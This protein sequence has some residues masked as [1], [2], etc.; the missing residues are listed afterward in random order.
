MKALKDR[1]AHLANPLPAQF[2]PS[3][4]TQNTMNFF[5]QGK[6]KPGES[7][8]FAPLSNKFESS[9]A[10]ELLH[11]AM[12]FNESLAMAEQPWLGQSKVITQLPAGDGVVSKIDV[13]RNNG[14]HLE[15]AHTAGFTT[16]Y[17]HVISF[18]I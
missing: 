2:A 18:S 6:I 15:I 14:Q 1:F 17:A 13:G 11:Q 9:D 8:A 16:R 10:K 12:A 4:L 5:K 3:Y 7:L